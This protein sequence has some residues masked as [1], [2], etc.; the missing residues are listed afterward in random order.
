MEKLQMER[1]KRQMEHSE[2]LSMAQISAQQASDARRYEQGDRE[3]SIQENAAIR[4]NVLDTAKLALDLEDSKDRKTL[5]SANLKAAEQALASGAITQEEQQMHHDLLM[6][7]ANDTNPESRKKTIDYMN[8]LFSP[9]KNRNKYGT[10]KRTREDAV[11]G[12]IQESDWIL[13]RE[14]GEAHAPGIINNAMPP[15]GNN[16]KPPVPGAKKAKDGK[17]YVQQAGKWYLVE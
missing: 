1:E 2:N 16:E 17:W 3:L 10:L 5:L 15:P 9:S 12:T 11:M 7:A 6:D 4:A 8:D 13:N 14:T